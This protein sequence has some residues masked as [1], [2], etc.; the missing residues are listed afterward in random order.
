MYC[1]TQI[2][3]KCRHFV[4]CLTCGLLFIRHIFWSHYQEINAYNKLL[5][6]M[7]C[8]LSAWY[9]INLFRS[10][11]FSLWYSV[12][13]MSCDYWGMQPHFIGISDISV[14]RTAG[15]QK[16]FLPKKYYPIKQQF[17]WNCSHFHIPYFSSQ[18]KCFLSQN[19]I[20]V[21]QILNY[22]PGQRRF[23]NDA[24]TGLNRERLK[25]RDNTEDKDKNDAKVNS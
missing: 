13:I 1:N 14:S 18:N 21:R 19:N 2:R 5:L 24:T 25:G 11:C 15:R 7:I 16:N 23:R 3:Y 22:Y 9:Q 12:N 10:C 20:S 4:H 17:S 6:N 8:R